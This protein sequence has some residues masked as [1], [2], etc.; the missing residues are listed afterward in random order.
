MGAY[1]EGEAIEKDLSNLFL[2]QSIL[3]HNQ[4]VRTSHIFQK[5]ASKRGNGKC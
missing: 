1:A 2:L 5:R 3:S 4:F